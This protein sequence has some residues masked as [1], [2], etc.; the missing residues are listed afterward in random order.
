AVHPGL[1]R[2]APRHEPRAIQAPAPGRARSRVLAAGT[3]VSC[4]T[5]DRCGYGETACRGLDA[6][7]F[8][9]VV[10]RR[11]H[12]AP[13]RRRSARRPGQATGATCAGLARATWPRLARRH[14]G[15]ATPLPARLAGP[16]R[17]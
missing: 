12:A 6:A 17:F 4:A 7:G 9:R 1:G 10:V 14:A 13:P 11:A 5:P 3:P 16:G 2:G 8:L 15:G